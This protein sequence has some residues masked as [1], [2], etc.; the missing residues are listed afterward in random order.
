MVYYVHGFS[1][2]RGNAPAGRVS[3]CL[4]FSTVTL[5]K[6]MRS[7]LQR[8]FISAGIWISL[9]F[10]FLQSGTSA[11]PQEPAA[12]PSI[13][14]NN[15]VRI[16]AFVSG[17]VQGVGFRNFTTLKA[18]ALNLKGWVKNIEDGRVE[19]VVEGRSSAVEKLLEAVRQGPSGAKVDKVDR[20]AESYTGEFK[21]FE[22][23][24]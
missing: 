1:A 4:P 18:T 21:V 5:F 20:N 10:A 15:L 14:S 19:L 22:T 2:I 24:H 3:A 6:H 17:R 9:S 16:H 12:K 7:T 8:T 11:E 23:V 13:P